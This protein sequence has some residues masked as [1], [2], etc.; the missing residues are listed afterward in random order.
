[1]IRRRLVVH[2][3]VQGVG[4]RWACARQAQAAGVQGWVRNRPEGTVEAVAE[5]AADAVGRLV[6]WTRTGP[7]H[8]RVS[9][10]DVVVEEP[11]G[12]RGF[13]VAD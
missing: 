6:E 12:L 4:F 2:G 1:M 10:V 5:G 11:E 13:T 7:P 3:V 8:A 9:R